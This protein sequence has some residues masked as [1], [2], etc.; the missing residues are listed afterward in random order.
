MLYLSC[1]RGIQLDDLN[2]NILHPLTDQFESLL[3]YCRA[4]V[5]ID[6]FIDGIEEWGN[7]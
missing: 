5:F 4:S 1:V 6:E 7:Q 3:H 2:L